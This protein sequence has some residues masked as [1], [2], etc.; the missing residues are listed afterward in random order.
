MAEFLKPLQ[1]YG[2]KYLEIT[3][4]KKISKIYLVTKPRKLKDLIQGDL[5]LRTEIHLPLGSELLSYG[6]EKVLSLLSD[7]RGEESPPGFTYTLKYDVNRIEPEFTAEEEVLAQ[8]MYQEKVNK[9]VSQFVEAIGERVSKGKELIEDT[10]KFTRKE[11]RKVAQE[12]IVRRLRKTGKD[13]GFDL[14][15]ITKRTERFLDA[16][17]NIVGERELEVVPEYRAIIKPKT[18][19]DVNPQLIIHQTGNDLRILG[20]SQL[21]AE[22]ALDDVDPELLHDTL[23]FMLL[24]KAKK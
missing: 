1:R 12:E 15:R 22:Q 21:T 23:K 18:N 10:E 7:I 17:I 9:P 14:G 11:G 19:R 2:F 5:E 3:N 6:I 24:T 16:I 20:G 4:A 13:L 8:E